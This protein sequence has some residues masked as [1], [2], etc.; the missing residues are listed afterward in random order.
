MLFATDAQTD[1]LGDYKLSCRSAA[2]V[3]P[4]V[5][6]GIASI[7]VGL[8]SN[9]LLKKALMQEVKDISRD[10]MGSRTIY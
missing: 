6:L 4:S 10:W 3:A 9:Y 1:S 8:A 5:S 7:S 2:R